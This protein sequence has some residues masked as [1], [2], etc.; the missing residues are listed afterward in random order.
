MFD[1]RNSGKSISQLPEPDPC[2]ECL[3]KFG[4]SSLS[5]PVPSSELPPLDRKYVKMK[6]GVSYLPS[7]AAKETKEM[8]ER[9]LEEELFML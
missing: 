1:G 2:L 8:N 4:L 3:E 9:I 6:G 5:Y 7:R